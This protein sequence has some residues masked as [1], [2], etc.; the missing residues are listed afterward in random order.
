MRLRSWKAVALALGLLC[1]GLVLL[2]MLGWRNWP[3]EA[4]IILR[5]ASG[6]ELAR[7]LSSNMAVGSLYLVAG[8]PDRLP[9]GWVPCAGQALPKQEYPELF[10]AVGDAYA[11]D[12]IA[13]DRFAL[14]DFHGAFAV[15]LL[16]GALPWPLELLSTG[17]HG[18][19]NLVLG[20]TN[21]VR[22]VE[23]GTMVKTTEMLWVVKAR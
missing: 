13:S 12:S 17:R 6:D 18:H 4:L 9:E 8:K 10:A 3:Q 21:M 11:H 2:L 23:G 5:P 16:P 1:I 19:S 15:N 22:A 14:P 7:H 20:P